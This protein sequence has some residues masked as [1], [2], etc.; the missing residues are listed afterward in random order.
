MHDRGTQREERQRN[1][2]REEEV[3]EGARET[4]TVR[5]IIHTQL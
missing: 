1:G 4:H 5:E 3:M 2:R